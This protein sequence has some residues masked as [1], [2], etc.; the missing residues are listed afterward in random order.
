M[1]YFRFAPLASLLVALIS[2]NAAAQEKAPSLPEA[3][4][5]AEEE[6]GDDVQSQLDELREKLRQSE[7]AR[8][9][10]V[11]P[12]S[13]NGYVDFGFFWPMGNN[14]VGWV[15]DPGSMRFPEYSNYAWVFLGDI[16][17]TPV[18]TRGEA[19]DLGQAPGV[20]R[21]DSVHSN[22]APGFIANE[23]N[24]RVSYQLAERALLRTSVNFVPR[25]AK[26]DFALGDFFD[27]DLAEMEYVLTDDGNTSIFVGKMLPVFG[28]EYKERKSDQRFGIT[29]SLVHRYTSESQL[30]LKLRTKLLH[31]FL[32][33][34]GSVTNNS[35]S[36][37]QF[38]FHSE[39]DRNS[40]KFLN[41]RLALS[42][43][44]EKMIRALG[45]H[46]LE[47]GGSYEWGPQD[48][49]T[50]NS[51][52]MWLAGADLQYLSANFNIK[53]QWM[54][55]KAPGRPEDRAWAL[56][57]KDSGYVELDWQVHSVIGIMARADVRDALVTLG[58]AERAYITRQRRYTAG[59]RLVFNPHIV[60]KFEYLKNTEFGGVPAIDNDMATSSL[61]LSY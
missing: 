50:D 22:G 7:D 58:P 30:G 53:A 44:I 16:L 52:K 25:S 38:H 13:I 45:G 10:N 42:L 55:G 27:A 54:R 33:F 48:W 6:D 21:F 11:S 60:A 17:G 15:R 31:E 40:G 23:I 56:D 36:A 57:L 18:N 5:P 61:V 26:Q 9:T 59:L 46:R 29:P 43:P 34:A 32:I 12:L 51:G 20:D 39:I 35:S 49:A 14:G 1:G 3:G 37:E 19:A 41:G 28:I 4:G 47:L 2:L 8:A 24:F